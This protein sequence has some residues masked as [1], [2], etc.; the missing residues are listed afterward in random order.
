M[1]TIRELIGADYLLY[2]DVDAMCRAAREGNPD[3]ERFCSACFTGD[4]PTG[5]LSEEMLQAI[6]RDR[7]HFQ[8]EFAFEPRRQPQRGIISR[9]ET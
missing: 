5:D 1:Q 8:Q 3:I 4:Y 6:E 9:P 2:Q 7:L